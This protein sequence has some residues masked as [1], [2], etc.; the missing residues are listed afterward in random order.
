VGRV[1]KNKGFEWFKKSGKNGS[2][3]RRGGVL[4]MEEVGTTSLEAFS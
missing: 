3:N 2:I 1:K 4:L